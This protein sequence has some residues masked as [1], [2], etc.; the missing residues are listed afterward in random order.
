[1][2]IVNIKSALAAL[3]LMTAV[4]SCDMDDF[5]DINLTPNNPSTAPTS[6]LF[7]RASWYVRNFTWGGSETY[8]PW[9]AEWSGYIS[10]GKN[11]QYGG[12]TNTVTFSTD[13]Y[14][15]YAIKNLNMIISLN[16]DEA[17]KDEAYVGSFGS[18]ANQ[19]AAAKTL[20]SFFYM[21]LT[22]IVGPIVYTEA[23]QG[24]DGNFH[25]AYDSQETVYAGI[26]KDLREAYSQ[27][28]TSSSLD[29]SYDIFFG[30]DIAK[31]KKFNATVRMM[32][33]IKLADV[34][35]SDGQSRF[36]QAYNDGGMETNDDSF[37]YTFDA[38]TS[39]S[40]LY[41]TG[42]TGY[43]GRGLN[44]GPNAIFVN[45]LKAHNDPRT[46]TY[47]TI[48]DDAYYGPRAGDPNDINS[49][50]GITF[51]LESNGAVDEEK[52]LAAS[53]A[54]K[55]CEQTA[56]YGLITAARTKLVE[57]EAATLGWINADANALYQQGIA[58]SFEEQGAEGLE[59]YLAQDIVKLSSDKQT[60]LE[61]IVMQRFLAGFLTDG[62]ESWSDWRR[63]DVPEMRVTEY[64]KAEGRLTYPYR[65]GY[66]DSEKTN[67]GEQLNAIINS[68]FGG[69][70]GDNLFSRVW[71]DVKDN[72]QY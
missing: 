19:I 27:F 31:W 32:A 12:M 59:E 40:W 16:E 43:S 54:Y 23:L 48:G 68:T 58:L 9:I 11:N 38:K 56:T 64:Q 35:P 15:L 51:G 33:A 1:M 37:N 25:P 8:D 44:F 29:S 7:V 4:T 3:L 57:A 20:R 50:F 6:M 61:Q 41:Y 69:A 17:T 21:T 70:S 63:Y 72:K 45:A 42:N 49:Y 2:K 65:L 26:E 53:V 14:Y 55:Y 10:E 47:L 18:N 28:D 39:Y 52:N 13:N 22:D 62:V 36:A 67:N 34:A 5:G 66:S 60:A 46:F 30:G 24:D 71:W